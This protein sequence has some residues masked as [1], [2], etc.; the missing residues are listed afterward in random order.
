MI[1][2]E[3]IVLFFLIFFPEVSLSCNNPQSHP[4]TP[5]HFQQQVNFYDFRV[6]A[7]LKL[8]MGSTSNSPTVYPELRV[9]AV[10]SFLSQRYY[11]K[12]SQSKFKIVS[13]ILVYASGHQYFHRKNK[14][15]SIYFDRNFIYRTYRYMRCNIFLLKMTK[16][17]F[18]NQL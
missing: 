15:R 2:N 18:L 17:L 16:E 14:N 11:S 8:Y 13:Q 5:F 3:D 7:S 4:M 12:L 1:Q 10:Y 9:G 6:L